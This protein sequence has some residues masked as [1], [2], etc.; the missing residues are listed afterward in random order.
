MAG[1]YFETPLL[2]KKNTNHFKLPVHSKNILAMPFIANKLNQ[3]ILENKINIVHVRSRAPAWLLQFIRNK[4]FKSVSTFHNIYGSNNFLKKTYNKALSKVNYIVAISEFV[5]SK[6][7]DTKSKK[8]SFIISIKKITRGFN[9]KISS[10]KNIV[11]RC[12]RQI[13]SKGYIAV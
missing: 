4:K 7:I 1:L 2:N 12:C 8:T 9:L 6:I 11:T 5:K 3:I 10:T 13:L